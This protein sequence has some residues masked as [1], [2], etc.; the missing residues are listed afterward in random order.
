MPGTNAYNSNLVPVSKLPP[1][2]GSLA[3]V[4]ASLKKGRGR[5]KGSGLI[6][7]QIVL[8]NPENN[9]KRYAEL[10]N[11]SPDAPIPQEIVDAENEYESKKG[12]KR[13]RGRP[14]KGGAVPKAEDM[15]LSGRIGGK[16]SKLV[17]RHGHGAN[18]Q[19]GTNYQLGQFGGAIQ[20]IGNTASTLSPVLSKGSVG[21]GRKCG[22][23]HLMKLV[24]LMVKGRN[25]LHG[26]GLTGDALNRIMML[27]KKLYVEFGDKIGDDKFLD[28]LKKEAED[29]ITGRYEGGGMPLISVGTKTMLASLFSIGKSLFTQLVKALGPE[30]IREIT[31]E[32]AKKGIGLAVDYAEQKLGIVKKPDGDIQVKN[33]TPATGSGMPGANGHGVRKIGGGIVKMGSSPLEMEIQHYFDTHPNGNFVE[34]DYFLESLIP[35]YGADAIHFFEKMFAKKFGNTGSGMPGA[36]GHGVRKMK[37]KKLIGSDPSTYT[38]KA[39][40]YTPIHR[41]VETKD[42]GYTPIHRIVETKDGGRKQLPHS[43]EKRNKARG[44]IVS[45]VMKKHHLSLPMASKYVK[46]HGLY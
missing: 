6:D 2:A 18:T 16:M 35:K 3:S 41:I 46:E 34:F 25:H 7:D 33:P 21:A 26:D 43:G 28:Y 36:N 8:K 32:I 13:K 17:P 24:R 40:G 39:G 37:S 23:K 4:M 20:P 44:A 22:G 19:I 11:Q 45:E 12:G 10:V 38:P 42:G 29:Y 27:V 5:K 1:S 15:E 30:L 31:K 14:K 9:L